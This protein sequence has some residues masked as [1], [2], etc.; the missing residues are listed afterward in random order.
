MLGSNG[1]YEEPR[2]GRRRWR[3]GHDVIVRMA[4][5]SLAVEGA[6]EG[7]FERLSAGNTSRMEF[8]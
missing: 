2:G 6:V 8:Q 4:I 5:N 7:E 3:L 1:A